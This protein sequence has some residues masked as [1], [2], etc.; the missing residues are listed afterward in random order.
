M[1]YKQKDTDHFINEFYK[2]Q[3]IDWKIFIFLESFHFFLNQILQLSKSRETLDGFHK[4]ISSKINAMINSKI[5][6]IDVH[7]KTVTI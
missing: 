5:Y 4:N 6:T 3:S 7:G 1:Q 2:H